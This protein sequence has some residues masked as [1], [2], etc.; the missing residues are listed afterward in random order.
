LADAYYNIDQSELATTSIGMAVQRDPRLSYFVGTRYIGQ[1]NS[2]I[3][4]I[5]ATYELS[6][7]YTLAFNQ[8]F[9]LSDRQNQNSSVTIIRKFDRLIATLTLYY[10]AIDDESGFR[11]GLIPE[12]L[13]VGISSDALNQVFGPQ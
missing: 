11:F 4:N 2:T 5:A 12:G 8:S 9:N 13:G 10:D 7:K 6:A 3:A 1:I